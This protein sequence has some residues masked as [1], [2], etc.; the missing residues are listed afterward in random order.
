MAERSAGAVLGGLRDRVTAVADRRRAPV[1]PAPGRLV[2]V[3]GS[4][5]HVLVTPGDGPTVLFENA[6]ATPCTAWDRVTAGLAPGTPTVAHDRPGNGWSPRSA[7]APGT[8]AQAAADVTALLAALGVDGP[9]VVVGHSVGGLLVRVL[10]DALPDR[11]AGL[12]LVDSSHPDQLARSAVQRDSV[13]VVEHSIDIMQRRARRGNVHPDDGFGA[14][15]QL[16][17]PVAHRTAAVMCRPEPWAAAR[18]E[19]HAWQRTWADEA[20]AARLPR[21]LP[22]AVVTAGEQVRLDPV[23]GVLQTELAGLTDVSTHRVVDGVTHDALVMGA[24]GAAAVTDAV[25]WVLGR[26]TDEV[27]TR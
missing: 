11:V 10:A 25:R 1:P 6:L 13:S 22:L 19:L 12:V 18:A 5:R 21:T 9:L 3:A 15:T 16:P 26:V 27:R 23:H 7:H 2:D 24:V 8:A 4:P 20:R 17:P 14:V